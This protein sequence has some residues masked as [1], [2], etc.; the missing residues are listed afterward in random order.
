MK[1]I[2]NKFFR[3]IIILTGMIISTSCLFAQ[4][5]SSENKEDDPNSNS[6]FSKTLYPLLG[7]ALNLEFNFTGDMFSNI[8]GGIEDKTVY[9][10]KIDLISEL[11]LEKAFN[12]KGAKLRTNFMGIHG[13]DPNTYTGSEQGISNIAAYNTWKLYEAWIEQNLLDGRLSLLVGLFDLN[14]EFDVR[15]TSA[16]FINP[17]HGI[18][19]DYSLTGLNGPSIFPNTS[20]AFRVSYN[21]TESVNVKAAVFDGIPGNPDNPNGTHIKFNKDDGLLLASEISYASA[22][23]EYDNS[24]FKYSIGAW[25]YT[26]KFENPFDVDEND[27]PIIQKGNY[28]VYV[29]A[30]KFLLSEN[31]DHA[32]GL[33]AFLRAGVS[34]SRINQVDGY[35]GAG[36]NYI[37]LIPGRDEDIFGIAFA[38][39]HNNSK[40][41]NEEAGEGCYIGTYEYII[42]LT[43]SAKVFDRLNIQPD[44]Q[45]VKNPVD[46]QINN[47]ALVAGARAQFFLN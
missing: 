16:I 12:W 7:D 3:S 36:I 27:A 21:I 18:G 31:D 6:I 44:L 22:S 28:G 13:S 5:D 41:V 25:Y 17:S 46:C 39:A 32:Q 4:S 24:F 26:S 19:P 20:L 10:D 34:D 47:Y 2:D 30:E 42:E 11:D 37:G 9:L 23:S 45:Y 43:Y 35:F 1:T 14:S 15:E 33:A 40:F 8:S 29:S 38:G